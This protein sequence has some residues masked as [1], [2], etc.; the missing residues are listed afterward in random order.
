[1]LDSVQTVLLRKAKE[2]FMTARPLQRA[3]DE[4]K[5]KR[6]TDPWK[7]LSLVQVSSWQ[8]V[9]TKRGGCS[10]VEK[11]RRVVAAGARGLVIVNTDDTV[12]PAEGEG[13]YCA[14]IPVVMIKANDADA[15]LAF[16]NS[17]FLYSLKKQD[18]DK[19]QVV[20]DSFAVSSGSVRG[21]G[22]DTRGTFTRTGPSQADTS[23]LK[24]SMI[25]LLLLLL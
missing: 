23:S 21:S 20:V 16:D 9:V 24:R 10:F 4:L 15:L 17:S 12:F 19:T 25:L 13:D 7:I 2:A 5:I 14:G 6:R 1:M 11:A 22:M 18:T 3:T 8:D